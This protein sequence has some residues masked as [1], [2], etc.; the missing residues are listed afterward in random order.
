MSKKTLTIALM[1]PP[2]E[3]EN[4][5]TAFR[6]LDIAARRGFREV[7]RQLRQVALR[8]QLL[9]RLAD[10]AVEADAA[11]RAQLLVQRLADQGVREAEVVDLVR[12]FG[13]DARPRADRSKAVPKRHAA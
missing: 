10:L 11:G 8:V 13:D 1:D 5:T 4:L 12:D 7:V 2:Y 6:I 3:S 9:Q